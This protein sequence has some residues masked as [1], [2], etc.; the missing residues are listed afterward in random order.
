MRATEILEG[1]TY[2]VYEN[3]DRIPV[4]VAKTRRE[5]GARMRALWHC[6]RLDNGRAL[7]KARESSAIHPRS[8]S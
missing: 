6:T 4:R 2:D 8:A 5:R 7:P 3:G 1:G